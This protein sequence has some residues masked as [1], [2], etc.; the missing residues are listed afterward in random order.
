MATEPL[1]TAEIAAHW[2]NAPTAME[3][4]W[5]CVPAGARG[6][7][8]GRR[9]YE[10]WEKSLPPSVTLVTLFAADS[11]GNGNSDIFWEAMGFDWVYAINADQNADYESLHRM[12][13]GVNGHPTPAPAAW[14]NDENEEGDNE[15]DPNNA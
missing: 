9:L 13:K 6:Q 2:V 14:L 3:L 4:A 10:E 11:D 5:F 7:G 15:L 12:Q 8:H 1:P